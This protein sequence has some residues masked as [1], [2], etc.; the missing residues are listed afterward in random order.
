[1]LLEEDIA[2]PV[3]AVETEILDPNAIAAE[4]D[5]NGGIINT[6][7]L[8]DLSETLTPIFTT[9]PTPWAETKDE[10]KDS[11]DGDDDEY[12]DDDNGEVE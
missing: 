9:N 10:H 11:E 5:A 12:Y 3:F 7:G 8:Y 4:T 6:T 1:M 2:D